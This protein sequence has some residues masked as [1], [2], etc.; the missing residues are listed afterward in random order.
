MFLAKT[1]PAG[2]MFL[3]IHILV[4][5]DEPRIRTLLRLTLERTHRVTEAADG[6]EALRLLLERRPDVVLLDA[7]MPILDGLAVCRAARAE[8]SLG[9]LGII[10]VSA[11]SSADE[12]LSAG[13]DRYV[14]KPFRPLELL[15]AIDEVIAMRGAGSIYAPPLLDAPRRGRRPEHL[16]L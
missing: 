1:A 5:D 13:A 9:R 15:S 4:A 16:R 8:P 12:A 7:A 6:G 10:V 11:N 3:A 2:S 14:P